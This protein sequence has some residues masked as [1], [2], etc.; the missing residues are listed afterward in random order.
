MMW[1]GWGMLT[2]EEINAIHDRWMI[3]SSVEALNICQLAEQLAAMLRENERLRA[4][5]EHYRAA[6][7]GVYQ[8]LQGF[9]ARPDM[10]DPDSVAGKALDA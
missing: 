9:K 8:M 10:R 7:D 2:L 5:L 4:A 6:D 3:D 1:Y